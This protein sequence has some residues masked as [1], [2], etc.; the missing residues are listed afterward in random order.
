MC[1]I[2]TTTHYR[3]M[4]EVTLDMQL[5]LLLK[6]ILFLLQVMEKITGQEGGEVIRWLLMSRQ[7]RTTWNGKQ[8][9]LKIIHY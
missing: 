3:L 2:F 8:I 5:L 1:V 4:N 7:V 9:F 6:N